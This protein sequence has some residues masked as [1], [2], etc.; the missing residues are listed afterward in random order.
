MIF[1]ESL[2]CKHK[3]FARVLKFFAAQQEILFRL[4]GFVVKKNEIC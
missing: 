2:Y 4:G 1:S 3:T